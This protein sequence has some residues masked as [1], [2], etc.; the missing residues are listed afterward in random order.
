LLVAQ[1]MGYFKKAASTLSR[2]PWKIGPALR[3]IAVFQ[4]ASVD[5]HDKPQMVTLPKKL[6]RLRCFTLTMIIEQGTYD[7]RPV[8]RSQC[9]DTMMTSIA[10]LAD[11]G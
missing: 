4:L 2:S 8:N 1:R 10:M 9:I 3:D 11:A 6:T 7:S 5:V